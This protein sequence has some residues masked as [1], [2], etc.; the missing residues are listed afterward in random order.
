MG[1]SQRELAAL[2]HYRIVEQ[3]AAGGPRDVYHDGEIW[4]CGRA[5]GVLHTSRG[6]RRDS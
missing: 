5:S 1:H 6:G 3:I 2:G 4:P